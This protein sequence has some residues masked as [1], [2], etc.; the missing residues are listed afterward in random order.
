[1]RLADWLKE[2]GLSQVAFANRIGVTKS[3]VGRWCLGAWPGP[4]HLG[5]IKRHSKGK[6]TPNDFLPDDEECS[7]PLEA[8]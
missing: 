4:E 3:A 5:L 2:E 1:M 6:V 7:P 8:A